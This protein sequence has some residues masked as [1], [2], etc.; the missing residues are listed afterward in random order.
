MESNP[1]T[2][3]FTNLE[4]IVHAEISDDLVS[5]RLKPD[6]SDQVID[7]T[8]PAFKFEWVVQAFNERNHGR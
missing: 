6:G 4:G 5:L 8:L 7:I 1:T 3:C 2:L